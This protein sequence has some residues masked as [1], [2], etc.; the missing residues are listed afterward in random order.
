MVPT[1]GN[2]VS[3]TRM[4][5][6]RCKAGKTIDSILLCRKICFQ[7]MLLGT[8]GFQLR[9]LNKLKRKRE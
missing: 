1:K 7:T 9:G 4:K 6:S 2:S 3:V 8:L 5:E